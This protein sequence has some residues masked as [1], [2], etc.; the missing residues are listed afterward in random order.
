LHSLLPAGIKTWEHQTADMV[1]TVDIVLGTD[2]IQ[3]SLEYYR[4][5]NIDY[6]SDH[7][8]ITL[9]AR[10][11]PKWQT[12][13]RK[14]RLYKD[15]DWERIRAAIETNLDEIDIERPIWVRGI[16]DHKAKI[17][18]DTINRV[19]EESVPR[20][21]ESPYAKRWWTRDLSKLR[22]EYT[23]RRNCATTLRRRGED[24]T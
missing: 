21:K 18:I 12:P 22:M 23:R 9:R 11:Q 6:G 5:H 7:R 4:I 17:F 1:S 16:L 19:L 24:T 15:A 10:L 14:R 8:L 13:K 20:A 3:D 2:S